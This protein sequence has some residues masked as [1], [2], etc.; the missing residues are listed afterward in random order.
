MSDKKVI[1]WI[2]GALSSGK[3]T[4]NKKLLETFGD[5]EPEYIKDANTTYAFTTYGTIASLGEIND[6]QCCGLDRVSSKLKNV[7]VEHSIDRAFMHGCSMVIVE[8]IMSSSKWTE[9]LGK[10]NAE[11]LIVHLGISFEENVRRLKWRKYSKINKEVDRD[12]DTIKY[13]QEELTDANYEFIRKTRMQ[14]RNI[15]DKEKELGQH[16]YLDVDGERNLEEINE[17]ILKFIYN[18]I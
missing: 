9:F 4:Q 18:S 13:L 16:N 2:L 3:T 17:E 15:F 6:S 1:I 14:Y 12:M 7:G 8:S 5:V 11:L 10:F